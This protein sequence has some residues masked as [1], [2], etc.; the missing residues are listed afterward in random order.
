[1][2]EGVK[3]KIWELWGG[4][5]AYSTVNPQK[6]WK[7]LLVACFCLIFVAFVADYVLLAVSMGGAGAVVSEDALSGISINSAKLSNTL[8]AWKAKETKFNDLLKA[9]PAQLIDPSQ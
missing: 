6:D 1:M 7:T 4:G 5:N 9:K 3:N 8:E 2:F